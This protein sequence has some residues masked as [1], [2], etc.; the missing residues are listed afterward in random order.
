[1]KNSVCKFFVATLLFV[2]GVTSVVSAARVGDRR[3]FLSGSVPS[4]VLRGGGVPASIDFNFA[5]G[6]YYQRGQPGC[7]SASGCITTSRASTGYAADTSGNYILF[8][9]NVPRITNAGLEI[10]E[11][12]TNSIRNNTMQGAVV[13]SPGTLPTHWSKLAGGGITLSVVGLGTAQ[14]I[15]YID[16]RLS[17]TGVTNGNTEINFEGGT[18]ITA[19]LNQVWSESMFVA[20]VGG[21]LTNID[22]ITTLIVEN[23]SGGTQLTYHAGGDFAPSL[24]GMLQRELSTATLS[25]ASVGA[26][27]PAI[28]INYN[29]GVS[30]DVTLRIGWPQLEL[31]SFATTPIPTTNAA[32]ARAADMVTGTKAPV[33]GTGTTIYASA[34]PGFSTSQVYAVLQVDDTTANN[35]GVVFKNSGGAARVFVNPANYAVDISPVF[36]TGKI[37]LSF[38]ANSQLSAFNG[39][40]GAA[41]SLSG[42]PVGLNTVR[43]GVE[44][45]STYYLDGILSRIAVWPTT[46]LSSAQLQQITSG[47][48]P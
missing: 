22:S 19:S 37:A 38:T 48:G 5:S 25:N 40:A 26:V 12:R 29:M 23:D 43:L 24:T 31:G 9:N 17:G 10:E 28:N 2:V 20:L 16:L 15:N 44:T 13:G 35:R 33:F 45:T 1:M 7:K 36:N 21:T 41:G 46:A 14:G 42:L 4:W 8:A 47:G 39:V 32:A 11:G 30:I 34:T 27:V 18:E 6:L 3:A